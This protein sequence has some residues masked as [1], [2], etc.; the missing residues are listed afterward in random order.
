MLII[1]IVVL[2]EDNKS[3]LYIFIFRISGNGNIPNF[4]KIN[5][6]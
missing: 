1:K 6:F 4:S 2:N 5:S 3:Y